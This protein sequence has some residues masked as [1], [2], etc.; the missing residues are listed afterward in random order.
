MAMCCLDMAAKVA[1]ASSLLVASS[2]SSSDFHRPHQLRIG[3]SSSVVPSGVDL[4]TPASPSPTRL[5]A[6]NPDWA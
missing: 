4:N 2:S 3:A 5:R 1:S 6:Q